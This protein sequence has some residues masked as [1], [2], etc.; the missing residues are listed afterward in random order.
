MSFES[1]YILICR[2]VG[3]VGSN[4]QDEKPLRGEHLR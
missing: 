3:I 2:T 1:E 4:G